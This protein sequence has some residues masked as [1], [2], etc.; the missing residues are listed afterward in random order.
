LFGSILRDDFNPES[1]VD[2]IVEFEAGHIPGFGIIEIEKE[3]SHLLKRPVDI[4]TVNYLS[5]YFRDQVVRE[6]RV[7]YEH[8]SGLLQ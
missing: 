6:A 7:E 8:L 3:L 1:D 5:R 4:R 2:I